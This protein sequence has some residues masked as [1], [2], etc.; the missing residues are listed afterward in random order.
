M[1]FLYLLLYFKNSKEEK[2]RKIKLLIV[3]LFK[4]S[5]NN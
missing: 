4:Y 3:N 2:T 1:F 5:L